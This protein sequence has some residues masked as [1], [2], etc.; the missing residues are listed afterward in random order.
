M[1][2]ERIDTFLKFKSIIED[3]ESI[4]GQ[5]VNYENAAS[6]MQLADGP[7]NE[8]NFWIWRET[9]RTSTN[10]AVKEVV[11][12]VAPTVFSDE[13]WLDPLHF[14]HV[15]AD[16]SSKIAYTPDA[17]KGLR[18]IQ[19]RMSV[20]KYLTKYYSDTL[21]N[22][23]IK[24]WADK[25]REKNEE[26]LVHFAC[27]GDEIEHVFLNGPTSCMSKPANSEDFKTRG[28][29]PSRCYGG[30]DTVVAYTMR[31]G[32]IN[33]RTVCNIAFNPP[34]FSR[35]YGDDLIR[36]KLIDQGF[37]PGDLEGARLA[38]IPVPNFD[39][40]YIVS[41]LDGAAC[42]VRN[43]QDYLRATCAP[44]YSHK[45]QTTNGILYVDPPPTYTRCQACEKDADTRFIKT[46]HTG[47]QICAEC[48]SATYTECITDYEGA[49][50]FVLSENVMRLD[51]TPYLNTLD[52][53]QLGFVE[54]RNGGYSHT[55]DALPYMLGGFMK[56]TTDT[57]VV[58][59]ID[60]ESVFADCDEI[61][62]IWLCAGPEYN[63]KLYA[64]GL[65]PAGA[66]NIE[67]L[68]S[69]IARVYTQ[70]QEDTGATQHLLYYI[71]KDRPSSVWNKV[72][73]MLANYANS[74]EEAA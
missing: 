50:G 17:A 1:N 34:R 66:I 57:F 46:V 42:Y 47:Q 38:K 48:C 6:T 15:S 60:G 24:K 10:A 27:T 64:P 54:L 31:A 69:L 2:G 59:E 4:V 68:E 53:V 37:I 29:H 3:V 16:D 74:L 30:P 12:T 71:L 39:N 8:T 28:I 25:H 72:H 40:Y 32:R 23:D 44:L 41:Y 70:T 26:N 58:G 45:A 65:V 73:C 9:I 21:S 18:D 14:V 13:S 22:E 20:G 63:K 33:A 67:Y 61:T 52:P 62:G 5:E 51:G 43:E 35:I 56:L 7:P 19:V 49:S 11:Q 55:T 36:Q